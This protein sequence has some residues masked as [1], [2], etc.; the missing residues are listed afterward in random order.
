VQIYQHMAVPVVRN[1]LL[2][3]Q[4]K[5]QRRPIGRHPFLS[6]KMVRMV[7]MRTLLA[8]RLHSMVMKV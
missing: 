7:L 5:E 3:I 4:G 8:T 2:R 1:F 6:H